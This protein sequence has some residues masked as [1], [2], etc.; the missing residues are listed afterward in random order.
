MNS[1]KRKLRHA[2][3]LFHVQKK[4]SLKNNKF[5]GYWNINVL[6][7]ILFIHVCICM[8]FFLNKN[9]KLIYVSSPFSNQGLPEVNEFLFLHPKPQCLHIFYT[10]V[11]AIP[12]WNFIFL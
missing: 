6:I 2:C 10:I 9:D 1:K 8:F 5:Y 11:T 7:E 12:T 4:C 3:L